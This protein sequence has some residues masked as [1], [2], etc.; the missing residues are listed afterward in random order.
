MALIGAGP[1][2]IG[3][4]A[5]LVQLWSCGVYEK[6]PQ[7]G[8]L[9]TYGIAYYKLTIKASLEEIEMVRKLGVEFPLWHRSRVRYLN[10]GNP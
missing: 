10:E 4:A 7:A 5:E 1:A 2:S 9:N 3:C 6:R 8:G